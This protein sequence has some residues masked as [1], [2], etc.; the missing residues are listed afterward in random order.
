MLHEND[1]V[2]V[3]G[4][5]WDTREDSLKIDFRHVFENVS[6]LN[7][8]KRNI[9]KRIASMFDPCGFLQNI[10]I[11]LKILFQEICNRNREWDK[12]IDDDLKEK[13]K[14]I[15]SVLEEYGDVTIPRYF[16]SVLAKNFRGYTCTDFLMVHCLDMDAV[17][18]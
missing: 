8:T 5:S 7:P 4:L 1:I 11:S 12:V 15:T 18:I 13:W 10:A 17:F 16:S 3:L 9:L 14:G 2:S 6:D